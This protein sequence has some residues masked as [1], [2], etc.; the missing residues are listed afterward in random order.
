MAMTGRFPTATCALFMNLNVPRK[1]KYA[2]INIRARTWCASSAAI[3]A[4]ILVTSA[5]VHREVTHGQ[6]GPLYLVPTRGIVR[7]YQQGSFSLQ[8]QVVPLHQAAFMYKETLA[9]EC[10]S[11]VRC[12]GLRNSIPKH[13]YI[14]LT[15]DAFE[16]VMIINWPIFSTMW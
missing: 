15:E 14:S 9:M 11:K 4:V 3:Y 8:D 1:G 7:V 10:S 12:L 6:G 16:E 13:K 2:V 5:R